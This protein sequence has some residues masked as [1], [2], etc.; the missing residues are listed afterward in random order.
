[1]VKSNSYPPRIKRNNDRIKFKFERCIIRHIV[2][3]DFYLQKF[4]PSGS[5]DSVQHFEASPSEMSIMEVGIKSN[6]ANS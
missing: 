2:Q 4:I 3:R 6:S 5:G 1:M